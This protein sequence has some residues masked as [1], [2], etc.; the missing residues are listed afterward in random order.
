[1]TKSAPYSKWLVLIILMIAL[2]MINLDITIV[3]ISLPGIMNSLDASLADAEW[4]INI[5]ILIFAVSL[6][7]MGRLGDI[8]GRKRLFMGGLVL[9]TIASLACGLSP[10]IQTL[11][12]SRAFQAFGG[13][14]MMPATLSILNVAFKGGGRGQAMGI[15]G[16]VSGA[17]SALGPIIGGLLVD[18]LSWEY[19]FLVNIPLGV[20]A[21]IFGIIIIRESTDPTA[22]KQIDWPGIASAT[23]CLFGLTF[24]LIEGQRLGW[25]SP[26]ILGAFALFVTGLVAFYF[27]ET[28]SRSPLIHLSL[29]KNVNFTAGNITSALLMFGLMGILF[30]L[31]LYF[32]IIL[33]FSAV[34]TG[35]VLL[36]MSAM[37]VFIAPLA[38]KMAERKGVRWILASG[39][40]LI[41]IAIFFMADLS[42]DTA[43]QSLI[44]PLILAGVG[45]GLV[46]APVSTVIMA[47]ACVEKSG[48]ASGVMTTMRQIGS[49]LGIAVLG[50]VL[51]SQLASGMI[52]AVNNTNEIPQEIKTPIINA[53]NDG[54]IS[55]GGMS[56]ISTGDMPEAA[57]AA[58]AQIVS[59][60]FASSLNT[61]M[62][63][64]AIFC[65]VG[66]VAALFIRDPA[67][68]KQAL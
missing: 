44:I 34:K 56:G 14:A 57:Q 33:G 15:W 11:V 17:A 36:P 49:L 63:V 64:A 50:A 47:S 2:F 24:A 21:T 31:I 4:V 25:N 62:I 66:V 61:A 43:W 58:M 39:M 28:R 45:M 40:L 37:V 46:M 41:S 9:F 18:N 22:I 20:L 10:N 23:A 16:A 65:L 51:Q 8:F 59:V 32:Q 13:A 35:L 27:I 48:A 26:M 19:I 3:N 6:I 38:G 55:A 12:A 7:T 54:A 68:S 29:F 30:L 1:M 52:S 67:Q 53:I 60:E 42:V 5:Y